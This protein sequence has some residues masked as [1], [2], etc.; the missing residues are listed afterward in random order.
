MSATF[1]SATYS[2]YP[3]PERRRREGRRKENANAWQSSP[4][5]NKVFLCS[6]LWSLFIFLQIFPRCYI[7][8][9][10]GLVFKLIFD[11]QIFVQL[12]QAGHRHPFI[13]LSVSF[14]LVQ[15]PFWWYLGELIKC[16]RQWDNCRIDW[17][18]CYHMGSS[19]K[20]NCY[21]MGSSIKSNCYH[22]GSSIK[23]NCYHMG[24]SSIKAD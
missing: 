14:G 24:S 20:S 3:R 18:Y 21:H 12:G 9:F 15:K 5:Q 23:S 7:P 2:I 19:I 4:Y 11:F 22:K 13:P 17:S 16:Q 6:F 10:D 8:I 1:I